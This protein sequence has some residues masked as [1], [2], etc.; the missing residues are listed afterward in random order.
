M[1][2]YIV[3][4]CNHEALMFLADGP[5]TIAP[6]CA[7]VF[8]SFDAAG[9]AAMG[10]AILAAPVLLPDPPV[11]SPFF[12]AQCELALLY[13]CTQRFGDFVLLQD[14]LYGVQS[15][16]LLFKIPSRLD[17]YFGFDGEELTED[18][19]LADGSFRIEFTCMCIVENFMSHMETCV[20]QIDLLETAIRRRV[21]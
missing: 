17:K 16:D 6:S 7:V 5:T 9:T 1:E 8:E 12:E 15:S 19:E 21:R 3:V 13:E 11:V 14:V 18:I 10:C 4:Q 20:E 2:K